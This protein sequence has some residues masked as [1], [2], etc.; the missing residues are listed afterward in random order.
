[1]VPYLKAGKTVLESVNKTG[2]QMLEYDINAKFPEVDYHFI[3]RM[4]V[5]GFDF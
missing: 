3:I 2:M 5:F 4:S 1:M